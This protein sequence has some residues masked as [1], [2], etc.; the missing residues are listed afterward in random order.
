MLGLDLDNS[1]LQGAVGNTGNPSTSTITGGQRITGG[2]VK[3]SGNTGDV[4]IKVD[5]ARL[6]GSAIDGTQ[7][8]I[9][10]GVRP[11]ST[12]ANVTGGFTCKEGI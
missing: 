5:N 10:L 4:S 1:A 6:L 8:E 2:M 7:D 9:Y 11:Y 3:A 12:N